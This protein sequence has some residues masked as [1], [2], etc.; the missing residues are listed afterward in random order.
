MA[1]NRTSNA[2]GDLPT[3]QVIVL[4]L[5]VTTFLAIYFKDTLFPAKTPRPRP[6]EEAPAEPAAS[7]P[8]SAQGAASATPA[9]RRSS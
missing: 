3:W 1:A 4:L 9:T 8:A 7:A 2:Q 6:V 5:A